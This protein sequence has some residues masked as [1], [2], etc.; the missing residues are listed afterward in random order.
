M[1]LL[2]YEAQ[3]EARFDP[4]GDS[5]NLLVYLEIV[6]ILTQDRCMVCTEHTIGS[7]NH[8]GCTG[9]NSYVT[10]VMWNLILDRLEAR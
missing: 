9:W 5:A 6:L 2:G 10:W 8:F 3:L 1:A 7:K 4:F